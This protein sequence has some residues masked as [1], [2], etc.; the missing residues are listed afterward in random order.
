MKNDANKNNIANVVIE[1]VQD[2]LFLFVYSKDWNVFQI[3]E[4]S[5]MKT[6]VDISFIRIFKIFLIFFTNLLVIYWWSIG[7]IL[8]FSM[9]SMIL[10]LVPH[11]YLF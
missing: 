5:N 6:N 2:A 1:E 10:F 11:Q 4:G 9:L 7:D 3:S 8:T